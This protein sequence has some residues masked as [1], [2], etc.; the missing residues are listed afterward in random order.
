MS[1]NL[2]NGYYKATLPCKRGYK[3]YELA[4]A[5]VKKATWENA[6]LIG[7]DFDNETS[8]KI[9]KWALGVTI[10]LDTF[11]IILVFSNGLLSEYW[12]VNEVA[13]IKKVYL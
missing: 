8:S 5:Y 4:K 2:M 6:E 11:D 3:N 1:K 13:T 9:G 12:Y 7:I 10:P